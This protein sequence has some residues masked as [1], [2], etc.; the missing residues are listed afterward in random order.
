[1]KYSYRRAMGNM[2]D[3]DGKIWYNSYIGFDFEIFLAFSLAKVLEVQSPNFV[4][5]QARRMPLIRARFYEL[6]NLERNRLRASNSAHKL[7]TSKCLLL[8]HNLYLKLFTGNCYI[9]ISFKCILKSLKKII[10][11]FFF[12]FFNPLCF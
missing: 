10:G 3:S 9:F 4:R 5:V 6:T 12:D 2:V 1:M 7:R 8:H 11:N